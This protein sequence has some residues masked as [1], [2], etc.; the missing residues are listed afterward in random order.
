ME[1]IQ[2]KGDSPNAPKERE[3]ERKMQESVKVIS[4]LLLTI[5]CLSFNFYTGLFTYS[6]IYVTDLEQANL[7][8]S[9]DLDNLTEFIISTNEQNDQPVNEARGCEAHSIKC[10]F[11]LTYLF[12][13]H[14][15]DIFLF[16]NSQYLNTRNLVSVKL[17]K[18]ELCEMGELMAK[19][20]GRHFSQK[21]TVFSQGGTNK[22]CCIIDFLRR[23]IITMRCDDFDYLI[24]Q[25]CH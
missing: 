17:S 8:N 3:N 16:G 14:K 20:E 15:D 13:I 11:Q 1:C 24:D 23:C 25:I 21:F 10:S 7:N 2:I 12:C 19:P 18:K 9:L 22:H 6:R 4:L 5:I